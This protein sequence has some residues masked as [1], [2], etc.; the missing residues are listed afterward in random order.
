MAAYDSLLLEID[1]F[2]GGFKDSK[3]VSVVVS[4]LDTAPEYNLT[5]SV[6]N[7]TGTS[8]WVGGVHVEADGEYV[9]DNVVPEGGAPL[10]INREFPWPPKRRRCTR[11]AP[12][13]PQP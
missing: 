6:T 13:H 10:A 2:I 3:L 7:T 4:N 8:N 12:P 5:L 11:R 1:A 9:V